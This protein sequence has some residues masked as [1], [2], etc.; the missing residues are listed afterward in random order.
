MELSSFFSLLRKYLYIIIIIPLVT[1][2][3]AYFLVKN[4]S[5]EYVSN[6]QIATGIV[7]ASRHLL[8]KD[9]TPNAQEDEIVRE[10]SN[11]TEIIK[12]KKLIDQV[13]YQLIIHD[14]S[15]DS[16]FRHLNH[17]FKNL[18]P[19]AIQHALVVYRAKLQTSEPLSLYNKDENGLN[20][21]LISMHYDE[22][23]LR[24][25][26]D[27]ERD[28]ESD[29]ISVTFTSENP[30]LSAFVVN[31][32]CKEF[33]TYYTVNVKRNESNAVTFLS[34]LLVE[35]R[36][37]LNEKKDE[38]QQYKIKN[39][40]LNLDEQSK[41]IFDQILVYTDK[42]QQAEKDEL[43]Y[44]GA[45]RNIDAKFDPKDRKYIES[46]I[47]QYNQSITNTEE[48]IHVLNDEYVHSGF[49]PKYKPTLDSL[50][51]QLSEQINNS[52][53]KYIT[54]PLVGKDD[55]V[56]QKMTLE[57]SRDLAKYSVQSIDKELNDLTAKYKRLV[58]FD[59]TVKTFEFDI[60]IASKEYLDVLNKYNQTNL[61][62]N[63][64]IKLQQVEV[65]TPDVAQPS[66]KMLLIAL[67]GITSFV[68]CLLVLFILF[69]LDDNIK[70]PIDLVNRTKLPLLG[71]LNLIKGHQPDLTKLWD[72]ENRHK[73]QQ[74][75]ELLRSIRFEID[76]E[77]KGEKIL[78]ITSMAQHEGK[79]LLATSLA[80]SYAAINKKVLLI[81]G[82]FN[83]PTITQ[84]I[85][86]QI[87]IED[88]FKSRVYIERTKSITVLGNRGD[89]VTILEINDEKHIQN[90][91]ED[92][93]SR[94]D[95]IIIDLPPLD[96]LNQSKEWLLFA[97]KA[98]AVFEANKSIQQSQNQYVDYLKSLDNKFSGWI[99]N[100][101]VINTP[102]RRY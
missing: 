73:M 95:I 100:K 42:K 55:L 82:N 19:G 29:F 99:L 22:R 40:I 62:S 33:I 16:P 41:S 4:L 39:D 10:F 75:K 67:S 59:A 30:Y 64:S 26:L 31:S 52:S 3:V 46:T 57:V 97:N 25:D 20:E 86:P 12:L 87:Y 68:L 53:D 63:F 79:T 35:K 13:S 2:I 24:K 71:S 78:A 23:S 36:N 21:L 27:I 43:A 48:Q 14:L 51:S 34:N 15:S 77:L 101:V 83:N 80:Y 65:A 56:H 84:T 5:D 45:V 28:G 88:Y 44:E 70:Q 38:L 32:L 58:P 11:L 72:V 17:Q 93:K 81:D 54:N 1:V 96:A 49:N 74:F 76:Q 9:N 91:F 60:D 18:T 90:E 8:D 85:N 89:D 37:A 69:Y 6:A 98:I 47:S 94:Y 102:K 7:D 66:K 50:Q 61:Q 92:L